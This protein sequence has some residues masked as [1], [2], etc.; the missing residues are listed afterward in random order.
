MQTLYNIYNIFVS[1]IANDDTKKITFNDIPQELLPLIFTHASYNTFNISR[2]CKIFKKVL[3][4]M[5]C[6]DAN[7][8][9]NNPYYLLKY[10]IKGIRPS[11]VL[12]QFDVISAHFDELL[13]VDITKV[14]SH[15]CLNIL[16]RAIFRYVDYVGYGTLFGALFEQFCVTNNVS[17]STILRGLIGSLPKNM[18][19]KRNYCMNGITTCLHNESFVL[20]DFLISNLLVKNYDDIISNIIINVIECSIQNQTCKSDNTLRILTHLIENNMVSLFRLHSYVCDRRHTLKG[21]EREK[22]TLILDLVNSRFKTDI[23][24]FSIL[25]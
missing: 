22:L 24:K 19:S 1:S 8:I 20:S 11:H 6:D 15:H 5:H 14:Y 10:P 23:K 3:D 9:I 25:P 2:V 12:H 4:D 21:K 16:G 18:S 17:N 13:T 7:I